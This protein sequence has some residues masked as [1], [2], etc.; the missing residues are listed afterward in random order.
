[1]C[2]CAF[3]CHFFESGLTKWRFRIQRVLLQ[4]AIGTAFP[5][6]G[7]KKIKIFCIF[8][9][10]NVVGNIFVAAVIQRFI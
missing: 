2:P 4:Y 10:K 1:M 9:E 5:M 8:P 7:S 3:R 6:G